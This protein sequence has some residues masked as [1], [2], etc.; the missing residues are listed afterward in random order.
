MKINEKSIIRIVAYFSFGITSF[1]LFSYLTFP[2]QKLINVLIS[3]LEARSPFQIRVNS[4]GPYLFPGLILKGVQITIRTEKEKESEGKKEAVNVPVLN[5][6]NLKIRLRLL[7]IL[8]GGVAFS[9]ESKLAS[10]QVKIAYFRARD[11]Y[12][13]RGKWEGI[14]AEGIPYLKSRHDLNLIGNLSGDVDL[15]GNPANLQKG[16]GTIHFKLA[17]GGI[18]NATLMKLVTLPDLAFDRFEGKLVLK[19]GKFVLDQVRLEGNDVQGEATGSILPRNPIGTSM[20]AVNLKIKLSPSIDTQVGF[21]F[22]TMLFHKDSQGFYARAL[23]GVLASP[24]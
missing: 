12:T 7:S 24:R 8:R 4:A 16:E 6:D 5:L 9:L 20:L 15:K 13:L 23:A 1:V 10:G 3:R 22:N 19:E 14:Q 17:G 21:L 18:R 2:Y 11:K